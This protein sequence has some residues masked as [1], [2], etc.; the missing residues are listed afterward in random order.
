MV[1]K[2]FIKRALDGLFYSPKENGEL[3]GGKGAANLE[4]MMEMLT[5]ELKDSISPL[6]IA[7]PRPYFIQSG[8]EIVLLNVI[9]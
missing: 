5:F 9:L 4:T 6:F 1:H 3:Y 2:I 7:C 8:C